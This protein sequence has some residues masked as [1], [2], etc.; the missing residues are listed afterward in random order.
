MSGRSAAPT[1]AA[2]KAAVVRGF[3]LCRLRG[4]GSR[5]SD[6]Q[7]RDLCRSFLLRVAV[8]AAQRRHQRSSALCQLRVRGQFRVGLWQRSR[9]RICVSHGAMRRDSR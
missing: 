5:K 1:A 9:R 4:L 2:T 8:A 3:A 7:L 6:N